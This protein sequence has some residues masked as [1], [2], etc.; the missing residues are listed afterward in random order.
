MSNDLLN[1]CW[2]LELPPPAKAVLIAIADRVRVG[3]KTSEHS[4]IDDIC[5]RT[6]YG[7]SAVFD[8][9][10]QLKEAGILTIQTRYKLHSLLTLNV[11]L[12]SAT[13]TPEPELE[14]ATRTA[15]R[16]ADTSCGPAG[17]LLQS[18]TRIS[19]VRHADPLYTQQVPKGPKKR[20]SARKTPSHPEVQEQTLRDWEAL[21]AAKKAGPITETVLKILEREAAKA[22]LTLQ[23]AVEAS[24]EFEWKNFK[25]DW[26]ANKQQTSAAGRAKG[27]TL[28]FKQRDAVDAKLL[29]SRLTPRVPVEDFDVLERAYIAEKFGCTFEEAVRRLEQKEADSRRRPRGSD[30]LWPDASARNDAN[31]VE[32]EGSAPKPAPMLLAA[33]AAT[34]IPYAEI[35]DAF[36]EKLPELPA[37]GDCVDPHRI[38]LIE[39]LWEWVLNSRRSDGTRRATSAGEAMLWIGGYFERVRDDDVAMGR[40]VDP[41]Y[42]PGWR[43]TFDY[44]IGDTGRRQIASR[45][46]AA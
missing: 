10:R 5:Q 17:G 13:R 32:M 19:A 4:T 37:V 34:G 46:A 45:K 35:V 30:I 39:A 36:H 18:A 8:A 3:S 9:M 23:A 12:Q 21:R 38:R 27:S 28:T 40:A 26:Y 42:P 33:N 25:A 2:P 20:E 14:S 16:D 31:V 41:N 11:P 24:I 22:S 15:V 6:C 44:V 7:R 43:A 29:I 1:A